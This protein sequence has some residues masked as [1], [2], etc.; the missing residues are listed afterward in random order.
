MN[1]F[2]D[3]KIFK[4]G[5]REV[6]DLIRKKLFNR[7]TRNSVNYFLRGKDIISI[8]P[9]LNGN[10]E[11]LLNRLISSSV[12]NGFSD[13]LID[14]GANIGLTTCQNGNKFKKVICF[15]PNPICVNILK[16]N[17][18]ISIKEDIVEINNYG[19]GKVR[20]LFELWIPRSNWGG[21]FIKSSDNA[22]EDKLLARKDGFSDI[23]RHNYLVKQINVLSCYDVLSEKFEDLIGI[24][25]VAGVIKIDIEG[26][27]ETVL[28]EL[29]KALPSEI[30]IIILFENWCPDFDFSLVRAAF[31]NREIN[32]C[33]MKC[34]KPDWKKWP[35]SLSLLSLFFGKISWEV[36]RLNVIDGAVGDIIMM[37]E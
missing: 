37:V 8:D 7:L 17:T 24:G 16:A 30:K 21:A 12:E 2:L 10:Y 26:M 23:D 3:F 19:L 25:L 6:Y 36:E 9:I 11:P 5:S 13:F 33:Y 15:E 4:N 29:A 34:K 18:E 31:S 28:L 27:E 14:I 32:L 20:G 35:K 1:F 22:Y